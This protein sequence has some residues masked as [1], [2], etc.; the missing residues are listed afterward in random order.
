MSDVHITGQITWCTRNIIHRRA[1]VQG[2]AQ[3][4]ACIPGGRLPTCVSHWT[5]TTAFVGHRH[6]PSA[7][8]QQVLVIAH[9]LLLDF[10]YGTV[11]QPSCES[12]TLHSDNF[13][14]PQNA[15]IWSMTAAAPSDRVY[16][17]LCINWLTYLLT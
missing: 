15:S 8:N 13:D 5:P 12:Q 6:V 2:T 16:R 1:G 10:E 14:E 9:S 7:A 11:C 17:A 4:L 3:P